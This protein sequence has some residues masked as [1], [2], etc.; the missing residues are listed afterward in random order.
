[1][2]RD[3]SAYLQDVLEA[4]TAIEDVMSGV[5][6]EEYRNKRAVRSAVER[7]FII[8]EEA[9]RRVSAL[10]ERVFRSISNSRA[11]VDFRN[12]LAHDYGAVDDDAVF[13]LVYSDLIVLKAEVGELLHYSHDAN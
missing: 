8:I 2:A 12:M 3:A 1:M 11:I 9:L 6:V 7:E 5:S 13:G 10:D 4:C